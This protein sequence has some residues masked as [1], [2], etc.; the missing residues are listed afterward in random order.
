MHT[1]SSV[2][3]WTPEGSD[4]DCLQR[5]E[6]SVKCTGC[7][8]DVGLFHT[9]DFFAAGKSQGVRLT[10]KAPRALAAELLR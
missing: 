5:E 7:K 9:G 3:G 10:T 1:G 4:F 8:P 6:I 2:T